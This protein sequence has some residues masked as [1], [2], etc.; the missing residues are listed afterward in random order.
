M[1]SSRKKAWRVRDWKLLGFLSVSLVLVAVHPGAFVIII[2]EFM[3]LRPRSSDVLLLHCPL[4]LFTF[5]LELNWF[6][7]SRHLIMFT[8]QK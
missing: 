8:M 4:L 1:F 6:P 2:E 3:S 7:V 5:T